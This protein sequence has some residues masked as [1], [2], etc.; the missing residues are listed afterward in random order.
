MR[1]DGRTVGRL[2]SGD[3][4]VLAMPP[5]RHRLEVRFLYISSGPVDV[6]LGDGERRELRAARAFGF[7][8]FEVR[9][10]TQRRSAIRVEPV[11]AA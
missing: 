7:G 5:G 2:G 11:T 1:V 10:L 8:P 6:D 4:L 9:Y 3:R